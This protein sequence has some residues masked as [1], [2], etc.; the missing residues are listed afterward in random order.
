MEPYFDILQSHID[1]LQTDATR[2]TAK[3]KTASLPMLPMLVRI[4]NV[5]VPDPMLFSLFGFWIFGKQDR[6]PP[7]AATNFVVSRLTDTR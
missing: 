4:A 5:R 6:A 2:T 3:I 1:L 7:A